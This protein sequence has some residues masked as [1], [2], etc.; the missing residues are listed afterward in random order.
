MGK[1]FDYDEAEFDVLDNGGDPDYLQGS[2]SDRDRYLRDMGLRPKDYGGGRSSGHASSSHGSPWLEFNEMDGDGGGEGCY[3][4]TACV[5]ARGL[6]D[7][8]RE[9]NTLRRFRDG[10]LRSRADGEAEIAAYYEIA[11]KIV[12][13]VNARPDADSIWDRVYAEMIAP[14]L[15]LIGEGKQEE[16]YRLYKDRSLALAAEVL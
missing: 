13:A 7:D 16:T 3:L 5:R 14:C 10:Y 8:C 11:P 12:K 9:L 6:A 15:A 4:T 2:A 1:G